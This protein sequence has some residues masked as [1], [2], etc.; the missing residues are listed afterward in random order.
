MT[1]K[2]RSEFVLD[3]ARLGDQERLVAC[4]TLL[5]TLSE[6]IE[7]FECDIPWSLAKSWPSDVRLAA[8][9]L[10]V[11]R[12]P[13]R[14]DGDPDQYRRTGV[15]TKSDA[16]AWEAFVCFAP[17]AFDA[18][19]WD[20]RGR[21]VVSLSDTGSSASASLTSAQVSALAEVL[22]PDVLVPYEHWRKERLRRPRH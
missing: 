21:V 22:G 10:S 5:S 6:D 14:L 20:D 16:D 15:V 11:L 4:R 18:S 1:V 7:A 13:S 9:S 19:A 3:S 17:Y 12:R 8:E 2:E